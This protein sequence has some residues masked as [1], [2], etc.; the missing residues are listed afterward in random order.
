MNPTTSYQR[1]LVHRCSAYYRLA[2]ESD[3][4]S[5]G[6]SVYPTA[7]SKM[8]VRSLFSQWSNP[9]PTCGFV[10]PLA[11]LQSLSRLK[12]QPNPLSKSCAAFNR[13]VLNSN[14]PHNPALL[15]ARTLIYQTWI[16]P[17]PGAREVGVTQPVAVV[18]IKST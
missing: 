7:D 15:P 13:T 4:T 9:Y 14:L 12:K 10:D 5:K 18:T 11:A 3:P 2:P 6:I 17:R 16:L 1:L 8:Y